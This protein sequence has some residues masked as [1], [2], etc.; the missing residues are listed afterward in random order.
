ML[1]EK[2]K[3][4]LD[5]AIQRYLLGEKFTTIAGYAGTGKSYLVKHIIEAILS[6]GKVAPKD[7]VFCAYTGKATQV[8][9]HRGNKNTSTIHK[10]LYKYQAKPHG[11]FY[12]YKKTKL[13]Y[14]IVVVDE[15]S[16]VPTEFIKLLLSHKNVYAIFLGDPFQL[17][18]I[19][20]GTGHE[21][22]AKPHVF[23]TE[24]MR[25]EAESDIIQL[26]MKIRN[27][28]PIIYG[29]Y[30]DVQILPRE[31]LNIGMLEWADQIICATNETRRNI[32]Q[33]IRHAKGF[34][35]ANHPEE[36]D[37]LICLRNYWGCLSTKDD[38]L[39]NGTIG[40][41]K[42]SY[43]SF[44]MLP[45][46]WRLPEGQLDTFV[47][48]FTI[49]DHGCYKQLSMDRE[50]FLTEN[51]VL[52]YEQQKVL[53]DYG[54]AYLVPRE[55]AFGYAITCHKA[56]GSQWD[57]VLVLEERFPFGREEHARWLYTAATRTVSKLVIVR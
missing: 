16:M 53:K 19:E 47:C 43:D 51:P 48:D 54:E 38:P 9:S 39:I 24:I 34:E 45:A 42:N 1:N 4:G 7:V 22:L 3:E 32:N 21:L 15:V 12:R 28:E 17:P 40:Y 18:P 29:K 23:L 6:Y 25:Q 11:G 10:L 27:Y 33:T 26:T 36:G 56:Q 55:F 41:A 57:N 8:L 20:Q 2:Q 30:K 46:D 50:M 14:K 35:N 49:P 5:I 52:N 37:K 44:N 13:E 31:S